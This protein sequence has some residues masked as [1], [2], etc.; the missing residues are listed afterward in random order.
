MKRR[1]ERADK[2]L[3]SFTRKVERLYHNYG[4]NTAD[5]SDDEFQRICD[6]YKVN[7][8]NIDRDLRE[9][10]KHKERFTEDII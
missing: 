1:A 6:S 4:M 8:K 7:E 3:E 9:S 10:E 2:K 5:M